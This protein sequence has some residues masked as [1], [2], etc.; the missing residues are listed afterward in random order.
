M[1]QEIK[2]RI[3]MAQVAFNKKKALFT[4]KMDISVMKKLVKRY[5]CNIA[6]NGAETWKLW[7][8]YHK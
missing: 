1:P 7:K 8:V 4:S 5:I 3:S 2:S 6:L